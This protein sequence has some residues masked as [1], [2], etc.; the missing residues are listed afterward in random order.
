MLTFE[1][2]A[3]ELAN[4]EELDIDENDL[5]GAIM[6]DEEEE[7]KTPKEDANNQSVHEE[8]SDYKDQKKS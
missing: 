7:Q 5:E 3:T 4:D 2:K 6:E 8:K 1:L